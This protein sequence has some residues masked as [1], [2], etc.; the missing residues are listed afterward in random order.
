MDRASPR[1]LRASHA[2]SPCYKLFCIT[3]VHL[4][5]VLTPFTHQRGRHEPLVGES[6]LELQ[7]VPSADDLHCVLA[8]VSCRHLLVCAILG[9]LRYGAADE[10][11]DP[12]SIPL[13]RREREPLE[14]HFCPDEQMPLKGVPLHHAPRPIA[15]VALKARSV[16]LAAGREVTQLERRSSR[17]RNALAP[18]PADAAFRRRRTAV[19]SSGRVGSLSSVWS[20]SRLGSLSRDLRHW[21]WSVIVLVPLLIVVNLLNVRSSRDRTHDRDGSRRLSAVGLHAEHGADGATTATECL[22]LLAPTLML[23]LEHVS[24]FDR[25]TVHSADSVLCVL[26]EVSAGGAQVL[27]GLVG[28]DRGL[29]GGPRQEIRRSLALWQIAWDIPVDGL[30]EFCCPLLPG[31][32]AH[33]RGARS[34]HANSTHDKRRFEDQSARGCLPRAL[35]KLP[36]S[37]NT[38]THTGSST[39]T[40]THT[41]TH[42]VC[43]GLLQNRRG[44]TPL[45]C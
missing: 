13:E 39:H 38:H 28:V 16:H 20:H 17:F 32:Q 29:T 43:T 5:Q 8:A 7:H 36:D 45:E 34:G 42:N 40:H 37:T 14:A 41:H 24:P 3:Q 19:R 31:G 12:L 10:R 30:D 25:L 2:R 21:W 15:P 11:A 35:V 4:R 6:T 33:E 1:P 44:S 27:E 9:A 22:L 18:T 26:F 23:L